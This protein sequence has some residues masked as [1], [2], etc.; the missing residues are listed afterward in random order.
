[1]DLFSPLLEHAAEFAAEWHSGTYR[2]SRWRP[3]PYLPPDE[4]VDGLPED[5]VRVPMMAH[6]TSVA[7]TVM[8]AG[9]PDET[10]AAAFLHDVLE[11]E[12]QFGQTISAADLAA[13]FGGEVVAQ[14]ETV[15]E[16]KRGPDGRMLP[17]KQRKES[18]VWALQNGPLGAAAI[19][20][21]DKLHN[22]WTMN[23]GLAAGCDIFARTR[24]PDGSPRG[25]SAG[26]EQQRWYFGAVLAATEVHD[27]PRLDRLRDRLRAEL[28][29]FD[30]LSG[31][32]E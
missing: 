11:D 24:Y 6:V 25:L 7:M 20:L 23:E 18:Y 19:S 9:F 32:S 30:R 31:R 17:W 28:A 13:L 4:Q 8:R 16:P 15:S 22:L 29:R 2:K 10:V 5:A 3:C 27:D 21:A 12:N 26:P 14:V 1:M